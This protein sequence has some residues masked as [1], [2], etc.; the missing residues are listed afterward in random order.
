M[1]ATA[2]HP[3]VQIQPCPVTRAQAAKIPDYNALVAKL[4]T[5][6]PGTTE[7]ALYCPTKVV[8]SQIAVH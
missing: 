2:S 5:V 4:L 3:A 8:P 6:T 7:Q 1:A